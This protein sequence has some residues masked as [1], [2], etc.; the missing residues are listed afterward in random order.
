MATGKITV[1]AKI[2]SEVFHFFL[3]LILLSVVKE[4]FSFR[5]TADSPCCFVTFLFLWPDT[6]DHVPFLTLR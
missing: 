6:R 5:R 3:L 4:V 1:L 2:M